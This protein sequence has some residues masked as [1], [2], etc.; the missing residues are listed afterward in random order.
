MRICA[1]VAQKGGVGKSTLTMHWAVYT[2]LN[3][4]LKVAIIDLDVQESTV[5]WFESREAEDLTVYG[6][7][8]ESYEPGEDIN[9]EEVGKKLDQA[10]DHLEKQGFDLVFLDGPAKIGGLTKLA[11]HH[12]EFA[13]VPVGPTRLDIKGVEDTVHILTKGDIRTYMVINKGRHH[14]KVSEV[15]KALLKKRW[16]LFML[17]CPTVVYSYAALADAFND[18]RTIFEVDPKSKAAEQVRKAWNWIVRKEQIQKAKPQ[19]RAVAN[20]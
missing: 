5:D 20:G 8:P 9:I 13:I 18:G 17:I 14:S 3:M 4:G 6:V 11:V 7:R 15:A 1:V 2:Q 10:L 12:A 16:G 19:R